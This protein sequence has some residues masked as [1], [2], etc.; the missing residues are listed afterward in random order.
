[1][2]KVLFVLSI[3]LAL[4]VT[5]VNAATITV[6][7]DPASDSGTWGDLSW[8]FDASTGTL[9]VSGHGAMP[10]LN[11]NL[12]DAWSPHTEFIKTVVIEEG[13]TTIGDYA[14]MNCYF[15]ENI[16]IPNGVTSIGKQAF[17]YCQKMTNISI[18]PSVTEIGESAFYYFGQD[19][20]NVYISD[21]AAWCNIDFNDSFSNPLNSAAWGSLYVNDNLITHL[22]IPQGVTRIGSYAFYGCRGITCVQIPNSVTEIGHCAFV[23]DH[24]YVVYNNS[25]ISL[26]VGSTEH[27]SL[28]Y[29]AKL[30]IDKNGNP[31]YRNDNAE[32]EYFT[33]DNFL[34][35]K[36]NG[37]YTLIAYFG[38]EEK[39]TLPKDANGSAYKAERMRGV[40][41]AVLP[42]GTER[43]DENAFYSCPTLISISIPRSV[44]SIGGCAL[45]ECPNLTAIAYLGTADQW[46]TVTKGTNWD[47]ASGTYSLS[48][49]ENHTVQWSIQDSQYHQGV[50][51][52]CG[53]TVAE[54]HDWDFDGTIN[55]PTHLREGSKSFTCLDCG[56]TKTESIPP[57]TAHD[58][59]DYNIHDENQHCRTCPCG[60]REYA[61]HVYADQEDTDCNLCGFSN[62]VETNVPD[63]NTGDLTLEPSVDT[64]I[65]P[66]ISDGEITIESADV[67]IDPN[68]ETPTNENGMEIYIG[69]RSSA[70]CSTAFLL[71]VMLGTT[72]LPR[73]KK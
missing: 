29:N 63:V 18:P 25:D 22:V 56:A 10:N 30:I 38:A 69:C 14:F 57:K 67:S 9:T 32:I 26:T 6:T 58:W 17:T 1:M 13:V 40:R 27:G 70:A 42:N 33:S 44:T 59:S 68:I 53:E 49:H 4:T 20:L 31:T 23:C 15:L 19:T 51:S 52:V 50:C 5:A 7:A 72:I 61:D 66:S 36:Q 34:F 28:G 55:L 54:A 21:L 46:E 37:S 65:H 35:E 71:T 60:E 47:A 62:T 48:Y 11:G 16:V 39:V 41:H 2:K 3:L 45:A 8:T 64:N 73:K 24:L 43:V 12:V